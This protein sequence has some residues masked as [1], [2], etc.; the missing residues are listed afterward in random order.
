MNKQ[1]IIK[2]QP[3]GINTLHFNLRKLQL[4]SKK[5]FANHDEEKCA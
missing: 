3:T 2:M 1:K 4:L 5:F